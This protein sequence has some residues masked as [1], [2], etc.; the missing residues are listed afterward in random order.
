MHGTPRALSPL[1]TR[2]LA[3]VAL[4]L[5]LGAS[6]AVGSASADACA[7]ASVDQGATGGGTVA[8]AGDGADCYA[9]PTHPPEAATPAPTTGTT[10]SAPAAQAARAGTA[11]SAPGSRTARAVRPPRGAIASAAPAGRGTGARAEARTQ[12]LPPP[13]EASR[14]R[15]EARGVSGVP[16]PAP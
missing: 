14:G 6:S 7:Y 9:G 1:V 4:A 3:L 2:V 12:A 5:L 16:R 15:T 13:A 8:V 10:A 11:P